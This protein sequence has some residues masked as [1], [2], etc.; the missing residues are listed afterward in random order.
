MRKEGSTRTGV[1]SKER[2]IASWFVRHAPLIVSP[3]VSPRPAIPFRWRPTS[4]CSCARQPTKL[5]GGLASTEIVLAMDT[6]L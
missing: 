2:G 3:P 5:G 4:S 6:T 1:P